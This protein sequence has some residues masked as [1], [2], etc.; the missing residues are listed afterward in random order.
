MLLQ[1]TDQLQFSVKT[2]ALMQVLCTV[3]AQSPMS[4]GFQS[5]AEVAA[6]LGWMLAGMC[7]HRS[8][9]SMC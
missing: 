1:C 5:L 9:T 6:D 8:R 2:S 3:D 7:W 4:G